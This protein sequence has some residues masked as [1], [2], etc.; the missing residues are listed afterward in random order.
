MSSPFAKFVKKQAFAMKLINKSPD[1]RFSSKIKDSEVV[2][3]QVDL[4]LIHHFD[5]RARSTSL[6]MLEDSLDDSKLNFVHC[7]DLHVSSPFTLF[8]CVL[9]SNLNWVL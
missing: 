3:P 9:L 2:I 8:V 1:D 7:D 4:Y 5:N 6:K